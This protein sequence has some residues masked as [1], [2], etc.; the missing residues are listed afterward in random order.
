[1]ETDCDNVMLPKADNSVKWICRCGIIFAVLI[2][3]FATVGLYQ[4][5]YGVPFEEMLWHYI[6]IFFST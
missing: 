2:L 6:F 4:T 5:W 3:F 1:M